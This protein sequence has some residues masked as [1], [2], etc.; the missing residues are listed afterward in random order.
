MKAIKVVLIIVALAAFVAALV[1]KGPS[2]LGSFAKRL[3][4]TWWGIPNLIVFLLL[5]WAWCRQSGTAFVVIVVG[6]L[7]GISYGGT[8]QREVT[9]L[10]GESPA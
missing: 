6:L 4:T 1:T 2:D 7:A 10:V 9:R 5:L 8:F 3:V